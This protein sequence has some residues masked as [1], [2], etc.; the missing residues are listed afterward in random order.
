MDTYQHSKKKTLTALKPLLIAGGAVLVCGFSFYGGVLYQK[1]KTP[2]TNDFANTSSP[3]GTRSFN[4]PR[5]MTI[6]EVT[7]VTSTSIT[8]T[9]DSTS[10]TYTINA[11]TVIRRDGADA[12]TSD[13]AVGDKVLVIA[14]SDDASIAQRID[15]NPTFGNGPMMQYDNGNGNMQTN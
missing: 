4:G 11:D 13:I 9:T 8:V 2:V 15:I 10:K 3:D 7:A 14:S 12:T 1:S 5:R 6:S